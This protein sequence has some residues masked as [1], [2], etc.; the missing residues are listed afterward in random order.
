[1]F[2]TSHAIIS[3]IENIQKFVDDKQIPGE[4]SVDLE[5][6]FDTVCCWINCLITVLEELQIGA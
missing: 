1:M 2:L 3:L 5:K 4:V 6:A